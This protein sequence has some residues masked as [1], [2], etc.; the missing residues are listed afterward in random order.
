MTSKHV[1]W[2]SR[3]HTFVY[4]TLIDDAI[5]SLSIYPNW[6]TRLSG[7]HSKYHPL[8]IVELFFAFLFLFL[9][10]AKYSKTKQNQTRNLHFEYTNMRM[11]LLLL[12]N[13]LGKYIPMNDRAYYHV[14]D[15]RELGRYVHIPNPYIHVHDLRLPYEHENN[16]YLHSG[17]GV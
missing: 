17:D 13:K 5:E 7:S 10:I 15:M 3:A 14:D 1:E 8:L 6:L 11:L 9:F 12:F 2:L 16:P 4:Q